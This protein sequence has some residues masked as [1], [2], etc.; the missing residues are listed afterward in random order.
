MVDRIRR[1][2]GSLFVSLLLFF[3]TVHLGR[4]PDPSPQPGVIPSRIILTWSG[5]PAG[6]QAVTWRTEVPLRSPQAQITKLDADPHF[7]KEVATILGT[8]AVDDL[9]NGRV[10]GHYTVNFTGLEAGTKY[11]YRVGDGQVWSEWNSFRTATSK[12][13]PFRFIYLGD[14]QNNI[15]SMCS[16]TFRQAYATAPDARFMIH[17]GDLVNEGYDDSLWGEWCEALGFISANLPSLPVVGNHD[18]HRIPGRPDSKLV[19]R[20]SPLWSHHF[21]LPDNG[22]E[23]EELKSQSYFIDYQ[24]VRLVFLDVNAFANENFE[25]VERTRVQKKELDWL[26]TI[27]GNNPNFWTIV[28]QHQAIFSIAKNRNYAE[29]RA[30]LAPLYEKNHVDLVF[31]GHDHAYGRTHKIAAEHIVDPSAP[32]VIY[33]ISVCGP[34]M[35]TLHELHRELMAKVVEQKQFFQIVEVS[36]HRLLYTAYSID[37]AVADKFELCKNGKSSTYVDRCS[38]R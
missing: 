1:L 37:C 38:A 19:L 15:K 30:A 32:G 10:A 3:P 24:G 26:N 23:V 20:A 2:S 16:R 33:A 34:K 17:A 9:G 8:S 25:P 6:S 36:A 28:V 13:D 35:Y 31:Q 12:P 18:L 14:A 11:C 21:A 22:P 27:L 7:E 29:M 4:E 5:D